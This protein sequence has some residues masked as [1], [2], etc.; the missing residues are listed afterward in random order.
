M[1]RLLT[2][3]NLEMVLAFVRC[4]FQAST[5]MNLCDFYPLSV[6]VAYY[7]DQISNVKPLLHHRDKFHSIMMYDLFNVLLNLRRLNS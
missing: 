6:N 3:F 5:E 7:I 1:P 4:F 2:V